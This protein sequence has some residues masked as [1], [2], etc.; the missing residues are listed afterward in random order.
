M[1]NR[2][3][4]ML[5]RS[6]VMPKEVVAVLYLQDVLQHLRYIVLYRRSVIKTRTPATVQASDIDVLCRNYD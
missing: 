6:D 5:N 4:V 1:L 2:S 3:D